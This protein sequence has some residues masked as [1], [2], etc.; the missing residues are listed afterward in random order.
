MGRKMS[1][2]PLLPTD[3]QAQ[4]NAGTTSQKK[5]EANRQMLGFSPSE[6]RGLPPTARA[7][8]GAPKR[9]MPTAAICATKPK[10]APVAN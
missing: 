4:G 2:K 10:G 5:I 3:T 7:A 9:K 6:V 8:A 1:S